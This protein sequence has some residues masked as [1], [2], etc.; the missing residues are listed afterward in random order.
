MHICLTQ[1]GATLKGAL[2]RF[3]D[4]Q[5]HILVYELELPILVYEFESDKINSIRLSNH[6]LAN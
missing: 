3:S 1:E 5:M 6:F 2:S 4:E